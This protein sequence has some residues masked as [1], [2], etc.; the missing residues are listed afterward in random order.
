MVFTFQNLEDKSSYMFLFLIQLVIHLFINRVYPWTCKFI[1]DTCIFM[2]N[3]GTT[4]INHK[5]NIISL[6]DEVQDNF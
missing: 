4:F 3:V 6:R 2:S 1:Q 5:G